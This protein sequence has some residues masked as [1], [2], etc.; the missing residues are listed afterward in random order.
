MY[1]P[2]CTTYK[3]GRQALALYINKSCHSL[4]TTL[5]KTNKQKHQKTKNSFLMEKSSLSLTCRVCSQLYPNP[6]PIISGTMPHA[7]IPRSPT[8]PFHLGDAA[9]VS[10]CKCVHLFYLFGW[11]V[12]KRA[13]LVVGH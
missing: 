10:P 8:L 3:V 1:F 2:G 9:T 11:F 4:F 5:Q 6:T 12:F 7:V 13:S